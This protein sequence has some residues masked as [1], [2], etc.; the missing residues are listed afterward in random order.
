MTGTKNSVTVVC[1]K[2]FCVDLAI[3]LPLPLSSND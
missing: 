2:E 1:C 3:A